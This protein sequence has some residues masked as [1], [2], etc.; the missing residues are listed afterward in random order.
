V[1]G[2]GGGGGGAV[3]FIEGQRA[4]GSGQRA[5]ETGGGVLVCAGNTPPGFA[6]L[7][8]RGIGGVLTVLVPGAGLGGQTGH[9]PGG[10]GWDTPEG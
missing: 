6:G 7:I 9:T 1:N 10:V 8:Y 4:A 5:T 2:G 3:D